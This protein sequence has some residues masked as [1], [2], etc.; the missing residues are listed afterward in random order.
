VLNE[1][2]A[3][4]KGESDA[5]DTEFRMHHKNGEWVNIL[6]R[7]LF[8]ENSSGEKRLVGTHLDITHRT[9][10]IQEK[11]RAVAASRAKSEFL[12]NMSHEIRTQM[13]GIWA[14]SSCFQSKTYR[15]H[16]NR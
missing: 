5:F 4:L 8:L 3:Y 16:R 7:A 13:N 12:A 15:R 2:E 10:L 9:T 6:S 11:E 1:V 14:W